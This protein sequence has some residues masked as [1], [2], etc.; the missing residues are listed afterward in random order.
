V[1]AT[2]SN[3]VRTY[4]ESSFPEAL[5]PWREAG[6]S[7]VDLE[8]T[9][10]DPSTHEII[11]FAAITVVGGRIRLGDAVHRLV[12]PRRMP[13]ADTTRIHGLR[14]ADLAGAPALDEVLDELLT[15]LTGRVLVAHVAVVEVAFL[16]R[17]LEARELDLRNPVIDTA[18]L[19]EKVRRLRQ[20]PALADEAETGAPTVS[21]PGLSRVARWLGLPVHRPHHADG[22]ALT[23]AQVFLALATHLEEFGE[24]TVGSLERDSAPREAQSAPGGAISRLIGTLRRR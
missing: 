21:S 12:R 18:A 16:R 8:L 1:R 24:V 6:F 22:D 14:E 13:D 17:A 2:D 9:G 7:V 10:L 3:A 15:R 11:S 4:R 23:T 19:A 20:E 5:T